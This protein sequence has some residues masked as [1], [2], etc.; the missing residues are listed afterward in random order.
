[1]DWIANWRRSC[2]DFNMLSLGWTSEV[3]LEFMASVMAMGLCQVILALLGTMASLWTWFSCQGRGNVIGGKTFPQL[4]CQ[5]Q[6]VP[7]WL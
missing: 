4:L 7:L 2:P 3:A 5:G 1:M 6:I